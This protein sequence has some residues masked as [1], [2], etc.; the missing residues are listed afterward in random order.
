MSKAFNAVKINWKFCSWQ[1]QNLDRSPD[2][3]TSILHS[4]LTGTGPWSRSCKTGLRRLASKIPPRQCWAAWPKLLRTTTIGLTMCLPQGR[5]L[6]TINKQIASSYCWLMWW[7]W[8]EMPL[9]CHKSPSDSGCPTW[10]NT[11]TTTAATC[12][13]L[14]WASQLVRTPV[15]MHAC[16]LTWLF[17]LLHLSSTTGILLLYKCIT[18]AKE[19]SLSRS[20]ADCCTSCRGKLEKGS[21][22]L[23]NLRH[24]VSLGSFISSSSQHSGNAIFPG[25]NRTKGSIDLQEEIPAEASRVPTR[26][27]LGHPIRKLR[28]PQI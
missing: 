6:V 16:D 9:G 8:N 26:I 11:C 4:I 13:H 7:F 15:C 28:R 18:K 1:R 12:L 2:S 17:R 25:I 14:R 21:K 20:K 23:P 5:L 3:L 24:R 27:S 19:G 10:R 22:A